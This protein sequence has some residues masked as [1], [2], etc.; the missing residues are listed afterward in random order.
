VFCSRG[1]TADEYREKAPVRTE[2]VQR[3]VELGQRWQTEMKGSTNFS[4]AYWNKYSP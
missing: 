2:L 4:G 1:I 3:I